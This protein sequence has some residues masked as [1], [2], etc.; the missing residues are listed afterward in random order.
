MRPPK[1]AGAGGIHLMIIRTANWISGNEN[2]VPPWL[3]RIHSQPYRLAQPALDAIA[4]N[5]IADSAADREAKAAVW[6][7]V[8]E[9]AQHQK[10]VGVRP[11]HT[12][13]FLE[14]L[15]LPNSVPL[16]HAP[17][18]ASNLPALHTA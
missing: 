5:R 11:P 6:Q 13:D 17:T 16:F 7:L 1:E 8:W 3:N 2:Q 18:I 14:P 9:D 10:F 15:V 4:N 12:A